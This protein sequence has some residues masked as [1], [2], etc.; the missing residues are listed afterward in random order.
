[1]SCCKDNTTIL[2]KGK[3]YNSEDFIEEYPSIKNVNCYICGNQMIRAGY[4]GGKVKKHFKHKNN[5][6]ETPWHKNWKKRFRDKGYQE[7]KYF[8]KTPNSIKKRYADIYDGNNRVIEFQHSNIDEKEIMDRTIDYSIYDCDIF[9]VIDID[10]KITTIKYS[11]NKDQY[12][13]QLNDN[14]NKDQYNIKSKNSINKYSFN[15]N[16]P[17]IFLNIGDDIYVA[18]VAKVKCDICCTNIKY[19]TEEFVD[20]FINHE[21]EYPDIKYNELII[22]QRGAG[23]GKTYES[24]QM[25]SNC[26]YDQYIYITKQHSAKSVIYQE[27]IDQIK[28]GKLDAK[29]IGPYNPILDKYN[30]EYIINSGENNNKKY[31][32]LNEYLAK[33]FLFHKK[34]RIQLKINNQEILVIIG[35]VDSLTYAIRDNDKLEET[36]DIFEGILSTIINGKHTMNPKGALGNYVKGTKINKKSML[37]VDESQDLKKEYLHAFCVISDMYNMDV[38]L[39]GDKLQSISHCNN[40]Y[41]INPNDKTFCNFSIN[42]DIPS[43]NK[44]RRFHN[45]DMANFVNCI[46]DFEKYDLLPIDSVCDIPDCNYRHNRDDSVE[47]IKSENIYK[48]LNEKDKKVNDSN[49]INNI[50]SDTEDELPEII[51][52]ILNKVSEKMEFEIKTYDYLP[53]DF[54]FILPMMKGN[55]LAGPL[56][57]H[58]QNYW[59]EKLTDDEYLQNSSIMDDEFWG[60]ALKYDRNNEEELL[61]FHETITQK[62]V[63]LHRSQTDSN[64]KLER[65]LNSTRIQTIH[66]AK[67]TGRKVVFLM[68]ISDAKL[69]IFK[70][71][72]NDLDHKNQMIYDSLLHVALTRQKEK[73]YIFLET[74]YSD[75]HDKLIKYKTDEI[76]YIS[77]RINSIYAPKIN[78]SDQIISEEIFN[79][80]GKELYTNLSKNIKYSKDEFVEILH[81]KIRHESMYCVIGLLLDLMEWNKARPFMA[82]FNSCR[83]AKIEKL[84]YMNY[85]KKKNIKKNINRSKKT[86]RKDKKTRLKLYSIKKSEDEKK[87]NRIKR[88]IYSS[89][90]VCEYNNYEDKGIILLDSEKNKAIHKYTNILRDFIK[91]IQDIKTKSI[92]KYIDDN[93]IIGPEKA[94]EQ[95][96]RGKLYNDILNKDDIFRR[97]FIKL[98]KRIFRCPM[99]CIVY[100]FMVGNIN[101]YDDDHIDYDIYEILYNYFNDDIKSHPLNE[102]YTCVCYRYKCETS[103]IIDEEVKKFYY[104]MHNKMVDNVN[105]IQE[106]IKNNNI[107]TDKQYIEPKFNIRHEIIKDGNSLEL[108]VSSRNTFT[109]LGSTNIIIKLVPHIN[110]QRLKQKIT[111]IISCD[112]AIRNTNTKTLREYNKN[113]NMAIILSL[114]KDP[115]YIEN[116]EYDD[117][118]IKNIIKDQMKKYNYNA[119]DYVEKVFTTYLNL[120]EDDK[121]DYKEKLKSLYDYYNGWEKI[122][123]AIYI[124]KKIYEFIDYGISIKLYIDGNKKEF[125]AD[126]NN[127]IKSIN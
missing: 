111:E 47:I 15:K 118:I 86:V 88:Y 44:I 28:E 23:C 30:P 96:K 97:K 60:E 36:Y 70:N 76:D 109:L 22:K 124:F 85:I 63:I 35:T 58:L 53:K 59:F 56:F 16:Q 12:I 72:S 116:I 48:E 31:K 3:D 26:E 39:I 93:Y 11:E 123:H 119:F 71:Y 50:D 94:I 102:K 126:L 107:K 52:A 79:K 69:K 43:N 66:S 61:K 41:T 6:C 117:N 42:Y 89:N 54:M 51:E 10:P 8:E 27:L 2:Y 98:L 46:I 49:I 108:R 40:T 20:K 120:T 84:E 9:W 18:E 82:T 73:L 115:I 78:M 29:I 77:K 5:G 101:N 100:R 113:K 67:G 1:M 4:D 80:L 103:N 14:E 106:Y 57:K 104:T 65:S 83:N 25:I 125:D 91:N 121:Y 21:I 62:S 38:A 7:E 37:I 75:L 13:I 90:D 92:N 122:D 81:H 68:N 110:S 45:M 55:Y 32:D 99:N 114:N 105:Q 17:L 24:I 112:F 64:I 19:T 33:A 127:F 74:E 34:Y 87:N 95:S